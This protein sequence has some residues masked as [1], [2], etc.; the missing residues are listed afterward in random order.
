MSKCPKPLFS[1]NYCRVGAWQLTPAQLGK[2]HNPHWT[3]E[4]W[5]AEPL[6]SC[7]TRKPSDLNPHWLVPWKD[8][9][10]LYLWFSDR[11]RVPVLLVT[12]YHH[13][14]GHCC[15]KIIA[16]DGCTVRALGFCPWCWKGIASQS[17]KGFSL[18]GEVPYTCL[19]AKSQNREEER[20]K[21]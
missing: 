6:W 14:P 9:R 7:Q 21:F 8:G 20:E 5:P 4:K 17:M 16:G 19:S 2:G 12:R 13:S 3:C 18:A 15:T 11:I 10:V 1:S